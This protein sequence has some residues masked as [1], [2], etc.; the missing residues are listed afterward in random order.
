[1]FSIVVTLVCVAQNEKIIFHA[2]AL[3]FTG[4]RNIQQV[5]FEIQIL[6]QVHCC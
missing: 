6:Y 2:A 3:R 5:D 4:L 1:M